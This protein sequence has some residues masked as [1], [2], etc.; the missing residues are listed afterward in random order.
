V[1]IKHCQV[2][3]SSQCHHGPAGVHNLIGVLKVM[4][5]RAHYIADLHCVGW[6]EQVL[7]AYR[8]AQGSRKALLS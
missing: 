5:V 4:A 7:Q 2:A 6:A 3:C 1:Y 8:T